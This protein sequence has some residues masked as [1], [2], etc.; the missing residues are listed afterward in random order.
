MYGTQGTPAPGNVPGARQNSVG[1]TDASANLWLFGG[2][3]VDLSS[4]LGLVKDLWRFTN[5]EWTWMFGA[6]VINQN[7]VYGH[8]RSDAAATLCSPVANP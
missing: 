6:N 5:A 2:N 8:A 4:G 7:G 3:A 1:W